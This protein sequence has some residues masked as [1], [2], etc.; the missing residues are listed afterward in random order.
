V[1]K[2]FSQFLEQLKEVP[3]KSMRKLEIIQTLIGVCAA[4]HIGTV[5]V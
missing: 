1:G 5:L 2:Q 4:R 3:K